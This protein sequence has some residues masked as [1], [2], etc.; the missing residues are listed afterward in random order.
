MAIFYGHF[1]ERATR[2]IVVRFQF[3]H[4]LDLVSPQTK[5]FPQNLAKSE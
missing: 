4:E 2:L 3:L 1:T 5:T